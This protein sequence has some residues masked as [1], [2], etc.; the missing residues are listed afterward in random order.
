MCVCMHI[1]GGGGG[2]IDRLTEIPREIFVLH[3]QS[4]IL[5]EFFVFFGS[6]V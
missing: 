2:G 6:F 4:F 5:N 3:R 1:W